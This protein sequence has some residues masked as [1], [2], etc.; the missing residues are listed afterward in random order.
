MFLPVRVEPC[1]STAR[2]IN[3]LGVKDHLVYTRVPRSKNLLCLETPSLGISFTPGVGRLCNH[4]CA[5]DDERNSHSAQT[6]TFFV[7]SESPVRG[8]GYRGG[9]WSRY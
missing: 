9:D 5:A 3:N 4:R 8:R 7:P 1:V 6:K 2:A